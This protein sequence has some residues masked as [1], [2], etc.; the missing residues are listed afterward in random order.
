MAFTRHPSPESTSSIRYHAIARASLFTVPLR[1]YRELRLLYA[2]SQASSK[3]Q[4]SR[5]PHSYLKTRKV[6]SRVPQSDIL[7]GE[8]ICFL[9]SSANHH[10]FHL[11]VANRKMGCR[12]KILS[13]GKSNSTVTAIVHIENIPDPDWI[14]VFDIVPQS[15]LPEFSFIQPLHRHGQKVMCRIP[16]FESV[17]RPH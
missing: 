7:T 1:V 17:K 4:N 11:F 9:C 12:V 8:F 16:K 10:T 6:R 13:S 5:I 15:R 2:I 14:P 3:P